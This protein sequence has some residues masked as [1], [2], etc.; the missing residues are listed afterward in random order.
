MKMHIAAGW[1]D[2]IKTSG[3]MR[4]AGCGMR[5]AKLKKPILEPHNGTTKMRSLTSKC[6]C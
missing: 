5:D 6:K 4:E 3:G 1:R 2:G